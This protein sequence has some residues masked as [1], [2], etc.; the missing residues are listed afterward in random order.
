MGIIKYAVSRGMYLDNFPVEGTIRAGDSVLT[1]GLGGVYPPGLLI[2]IV[3][4]VEY[5][6]DRPFCNVSVRPFVNTYAIEEL[7]IL[8][9]D[10]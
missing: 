5:P 10:N 4:G 8:K 1:S 3:T 2:G 9:V 6:N 7:F